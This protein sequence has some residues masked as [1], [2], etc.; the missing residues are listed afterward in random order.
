MLRP[1]L[2][3]SL[4]L[5]MLMLLGG[6]AT[7]AIDGGF[8]YLERDSQGRF[9]P[10]Y[11]SSGSTTLLADR[12]SIT[13]PSISADGTRVAF[14]GAIG[15]ESHGAYAI[16]LVNTNGSGLTQLTA[17]S[18]GELDPDWSPDGSSL[19][20]SLNNT[21]SITATSCC[22]LATV[23][24]TTGVVTTL[25][26]NVGAIRP[27]Y[28][29]NGASIL[30]DNPAGVWTISSAGGAATLRAAGGRDATFSPDSGSIAFLTTSGAT[31]SIQTVSAAGG[32]A[33]IRYS[34]SR[35]IE[36]PVWVGSR[37]YFI[38]YTG[39]GWDGR[40]S[41]QI[42]SV[43]AAGGTAVVER[44]FSGPVAGLSMSG[45]DPAD[46]MFFYRDDGLYRY[47]DIRSNGTLPAPILAGSGYTAGW[48]SIVSV[49]LDGDG[50]DE[51]LFYRQDGLYRYYHVRP[52][53]TLP[54]PLLAGDDYTNGLDQIAAIDL[55]GD[56]QDE[57]FVYRDDGL[58]RYYDINADGTLPAPLLQGSGYT[59]G[60]DSI[61]GVDLDGDGQ[62]E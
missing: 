61:T 50:Q 10:V 48:D 31:T 43:P 19:V 54:V 38:E 35:S 42:R 4:A 34:T 25:T 49:D 53:G 30:Y 14:S 36:S 45:G 6:A 15:N 9:R 41:V 57:L 47:Y 60:W 62:D 59:A 1:A 40:T 29:P 27:S 52:D 7:A 46:E 13:A 18:Y 22:K 16:Y 17:G 28:A 32:T 3:A 20:F 37:I 24:T 55:D 58:F 21:G 56:G 33:T 51:M 23:D 12:D 26:D 11:E 8:T 2:L 5:T 44:S 39:S